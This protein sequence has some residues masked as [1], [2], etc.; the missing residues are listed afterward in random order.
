MSRLA[1]LAF[2]LSGRISRQTFWIA[3]I[4]YFAVLIGGIAVIQPEYLTRPEIII[5]SFAHNV[6]MLLMAWPSFAI[7]KKR[8][9]DRDWPD[10]VFIG[11]VLISA[12]FFI[13]P[14]F[15]LLI[16]P[17]APAVWEQVIWV[18]FGVAMLLLLV[19]NGFMKGTD[20]PN[21]FGPDPQAPQPSRA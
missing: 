14:F 11:V 10:W 13:G 7:T 2:S 16:D 12:P 8:L 1:W 3:L 20:G 5:P 18:V 4:V 15:G 6:W 19:D 17:G 9:N 21:R